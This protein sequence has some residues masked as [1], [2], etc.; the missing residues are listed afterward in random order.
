M[1]GILV[2]L[3]LT[4][5]LGCGDDDSDGSVDAFTPMDV[6]TEGS[7]VGGACATEAD[8][9]A[10]LQCDDGLAD[11][12]GRGWPEGYC[13]RGCSTDADCPFGA[14]CAVRYFDDA[15]NEVLG[16]MATCERDAA[17]RGGCRD[18]YV[19]SFDGLCDLGCTTDEHCRNAGRPNA[20][21]ELDTGRCNF[22]EVAGALD[23]DDC[24]IDADCGP[25]QTC[26]VGRCT[27]YNCDL[28]GEWACTNGWTCSTLPLAWD[29][30]LSLCSP[31]CDFMGT[32]PA[33]SE[34][35]PEEADP[36]GAATGPHCFL[37]ASNGGGASPDARIGDACSTNADCPPRGGLESCQNG[38]CTSLYCAAA[39]LPS[40]LAGCEDGAVCWT[41]DLDPDVVGRTNSEFAALGVC[42][43][44]CSADADVCSAGQTCFEGACVDG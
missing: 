34:C 42:R 27:T 7:P 32:C 1:R 28:G 3:L 18:G 26:I 12:R 31:P 22:G 35:V 33:A 37:S 14:R 9:R 29:A 11:S 8:C 25:H 23:G 16:C 4:S 30:L 5:L 41:V 40:A 44:D 2:G 6:V 19:C 24:S 21:C 20:V 10:G 13:T 39:S 17:S 15:D 38:F 43:R 36:S